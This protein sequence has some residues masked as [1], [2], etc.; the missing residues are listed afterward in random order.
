LEG[1]LVVGEAP[2]VVVVA[3]AA[4]VVV[5]AGTVVSVVVGASEPLEQAT[6]TSSNT[7]RREIR[8]SIT[9]RISAAPG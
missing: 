4:V 5:S 2:S 7:R 1:T 3:S 6:A 8:R 9:S